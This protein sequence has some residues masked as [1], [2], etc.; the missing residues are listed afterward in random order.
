MKRFWL[1]LGAT[2]LCQTRG[3]ADDAAVLYPE[4][5]RLAREPGFFA[6][7]IVPRF[8]LFAELAGFLLAL[9]GIFWFVRRKHAQDRARAAT[10]HQTADGGAEPQ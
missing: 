10:K 1:L 2:L 4:A 8:S 3:L 7:C 9:L 5:E 6:Q